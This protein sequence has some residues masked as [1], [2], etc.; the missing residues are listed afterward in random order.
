M[1]F[2]VDAIKAFAAPGS[3]APITLTVLASRSAGSAFA[4]AVL[5]AIRT[6]FTLRSSKN[7]W[8]RSEYFST[9]R[10]LLLP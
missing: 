2:V 9:V 5:Q 3:T 1:C 7:F 6:S 10:G 4:D 8:H